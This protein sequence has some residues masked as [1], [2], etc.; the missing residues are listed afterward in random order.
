MATAAGCMEACELLLKYGADVEAVDGLGRTPESLLPPDQVPLFTQLAG[1]Y[2]G[3]ERP[4]QLCFCGEGKLY[5]Q[6][7]AGALIR[8]GWVFSRGVC[9]P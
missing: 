1:R 9:A 2:R 4:P 3:A 7:H 6:C 5:S 8:V